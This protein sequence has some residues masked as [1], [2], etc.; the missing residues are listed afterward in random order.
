MRFATITTGS[1]GPIDF[2]GAILAYMGW[3]SA[4]KDQQLGAIDGFTPEQRFFIGFAQWACANER[5]GPIPGLARHRP[6]LLQRSSSPSHR[7]YLV[8]D[9]RQQPRAVL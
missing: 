5:P 8:G 4:V 3:T 9:P 1:P 2:I 6:L 7:R